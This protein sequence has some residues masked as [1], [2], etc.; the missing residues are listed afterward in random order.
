MEI[1]E[2]VDPTRRGLYGGVVVYFDL[3]GNTDMAIAIR[4]A[5]IKDGIAHVQ[6]G[7]GIVADSTAAAGGTESRNKAAA[8]IRAVQVAAGVRPLSPRRTQ[9]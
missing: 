9:R 8:A 4:T 5:L 2:L 3:A 6:A 1:S 7:G